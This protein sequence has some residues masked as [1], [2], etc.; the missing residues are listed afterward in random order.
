MKGSDA[1][2]AAATFAAIVASFVLPAA[3]ASAQNFPTKPL[4]AIT[5]QGAGGL[6]DIFMRGLAD[7]LGPAL[8]QNVVVENRVGAAGTVGARACA[9]APP[10]GYTFCILPDTA[11]VYNPITL[12]K[13][14]FDPKAK[15]AAITRIYN[16]TQVFAVTAAL[17][18]KNFEELIKHTKA[19]PKTMSYMAPSLAKVA[20]MNELNKKHGTDFVRVPF[21]GGGD[22]VNSMLSNT[23]QIAVFGIG[24]LAQLIKAGKIV[25]LAMDG[26]KR[27]PLAPDVPTFKEAGYDVEGLTFFGLYAPIGTPKPILEKIYAETKKI[28]EKPDFQKK[29]LLGRGL[30]P[31]LSSPDEFEKD[32]VKERQ[33]AKRIIIESG[34]YPHVK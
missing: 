11:I 29:F 17:K 4:K 30:V 32:L 25:G 20:F 14:D 2:R 28:V 13:Q 16:L 27:N 6:S 22:A 8:G 9:E 15:L 5:S 23:T 34:L 33:V 10:D 26:D 7:Q 3:N 1:M 12:P 21:K 18:V 31:V 19:N 24:N